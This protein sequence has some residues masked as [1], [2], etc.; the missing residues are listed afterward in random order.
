MSPSSPSLRSSSSSVSAAPLCVAQ[1]CGSVAK[2]VCAKCSDDTNPWFL[3]DEHNRKYHKQ[4]N[5]QKHFRTT[6]QQYQQEDQFIRLVNHQ[7]GSDEY[8]RDQIVNLFFGVPVP[9]EIG[10]PTL[11]LGNKYHTLGMQFASDVEMGMISFIA[12]TGSGKS[13]L[14]RWFVHSGSNSDPSLP[15]AA[16]HGD[17]TS[18][19]A[20]L[21]A[22]F[23]RWNINLAPPDVGTRL[24][25]I[26]CIDSEGLR[27]SDIPRQAGFMLRLLS[28][29]SE[30]SNDRLAKFRA[31]MVEMVY[32]RLLYMFS[33]VILY[34]FVGS[35]AEIQSYGQDLLEF[36]AI[37]SARTVNSA[38]LPSLCII[39]NKRA[40]QDCHGYLQ[41]EGEANEASITRA[42]EA[43]IGQH[44][45]IFE[46]L[47]LVFREVK[48]IHI[49]NCVDHPREGLTALTQLKLL[50]Q[51]LV[52]E[53]VAARAATDKIQRQ[54][55]LFSNLWSMANRLGADP[56][57]NINLFSLFLN[58][59]EIAATGIERSSHL[60]AYW[61]ALMR[62]FKDAVEDAR[63]KLPVHI[64][65]LLRNRW[66]TTELATGYRD[67][68]QKELEVLARQVQLD[69]RCTATKE[70]RC[71]R[72]GVIS[73]RCELYHRSHLGQ[74]H[75]STQTYVTSQPSSAWYKKIF[76]SRFI[77]APCVW[78]GSFEG[79]DIAPELIEYISHVYDTMVPVS[80]SSSEY[81]RAL[82]LALL[83]KIAK[84]QP[85]VA[86]K[87][88]LVCVWNSPTVP[89]VCGHCL[90]PGCFGKYANVSPCLCP[91][92]TQQTKRALQE[93]PKSAGIRVL[94]L[95]GGGVR[96]VIQLVVLRQIAALTG[97]PIAKLFDLIVGTS[98]GGILALYLTSKTSEVADAKLN[99]PERGIDLIKSIASDVFGEPTSS[100]WK[101][102]SL[103]FGS[104]YSK[105]S[106]E[107]LS[108][109]LSRNMKESYNKPLRGYASPAPVVAVTMVKVASSSLVVASSA[110][111]AMIEGDIGCFTTVG[112]A[113]MGTSAAPTYF[114]HVTINDKLYVDGGM[115]ANCPANKAIDI[116]QS[117]WPEQ[118]IDMVVSIGTGLC[119]A[120]AE[121]R[122]SVIEAIG[123]VV[124][125][126]TDSEHQSAKAK[127]RMQRE[128]PSRPYIRLNVEI[129]QP[130]DL[131]TCDVAAIDAMIGAAARLCE[132]SERCEEIAGRLIA[133]LLFVK[134]NGPN[135]AKV[136]RFEVVSR[137]PQERPVESLCRD[138]GLYYTFQRNV[139]PEQTSELGAARSSTIDL[140]PGKY[141]IAFMLRTKYGG[142]PLSGFPMTLNV[143]PARY[144]D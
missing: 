99:S 64:P 109:V 90:C 140:E 71:A 10:D 57:G 50:T 80:Y 134:S 79:P 83:L 137:L 139:D 34:P 22:Y 3:C 129:E 65:L 106:G 45:D 27:G 87:I 55:D 9:A 131:D 81:L 59:P 29:K 110:S 111:G 37:A 69:S 141:L 35:P 56:D 73:V 98:A 75:K 16:N 23:T 38:V 89:L 25:P 135:I 108:E 7:A 86:D 42:T 44:R 78:R 128:L 76:N 84:Q 122:G 12:P 2:W 123:L 5:T 142:F 54:G 125:L 93:V 19:S 39:F 49:P 33:D 13:L 113:C 62:H 82:D 53:G 21:H 63:E 120:Q 30:K 61:H 88:C 103:L 116:A 118:T 126:L 138:G 32:P 70:F 77:S 107:K 4:P 18:C 14:L 46:Q 119:N 8:E 143:N 101:F 97:L 1:D 60:L 20:D 68:W 26:I 43:W 40:M 102:L 15:L 58:D 67:T 72:K 121:S 95:D 48:V 41:Q 91:L 114:P 66:G 28:F 132:S 136:F 94:S 47:R 17:Q 130:Y 105:Y 127:E 24:M 36:S 74:P 115:R 92:C 104:A 124:N 96:A 11:E 51:R 133:Q 100:V 6:W 52:S 144:T 85:D 31:R 117:L 112:Q